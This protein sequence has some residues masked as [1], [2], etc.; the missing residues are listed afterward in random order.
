MINQ[1]LR[2]LSCVVLL[3]INSY[4]YADTSSEFYE[5]ALAKFN[6]EKFED[7]YIH[8]KNSLQQNPENLPAKIL[9]GKVLLI[10]GYLYEA[11]EILQESLASGADPSLIADTLGKVWLFTKQYDKIIDAKFSGLNNESRLEWQ[12]IKATANLNIKDFNGAREGYQKALKQAPNN[13]KVL[14]ALIAL[15]TQQ[16]NFDQAQQYLNTTFSTDINNA[17]TWRLQ[18]DL[19]LAKGNVNQAIEAYQKGFELNSSDPLIKRSLVSAFMQ[20]KDTEAARNLLNTVLEQTPDDPTGLLLKAWLLSM[21]QQNQEAIDQLEKLS[22][23]LASVTE[24]SQRND[25]SLIYISALAAYAQQNFQQ[26]KTYFI[27]YLNFV[28]DNIDAI[29]LLAETLLKLNQPKPALEAMQRHERKL[30]ENF[31][32]AL[33]LGELYLANDKAFKTVELLRKLKAD[34][35]NEPQV[36][37]LDIKTDIDRGKTQ[38]AL[39]RLNANPLINT[40]LGF[41]LTKTRL[42]I[43]LAEYSQANDI[44]DQLLSYGPNN[45]E[46]LNLKAAVLIKLQNWEDAEKY[47]DRALLES[48]ENFSGR[49]AKA[50]ILS[51]QKKFD[52]ALDLVNGLSQIQPDNLSVL[53][54]KGSIL[55][56]L[57]DREGAVTH[58]ERVL[59]K[60]ISNLTAMQMLANIYIANG[61]LDK[62]IR[63]LS[64]A[65]K[66]APD[67]ISYQLQ[68]I[69]VYLD[70]KQDERAK[71]ELQK[72]IHLASEDPTALLQISRLQFKANE[73]QA[74]QKSVAMAYQLMPDSFTL[75]QEY[76]RMFI[77]TN[78]LDEARKM[79]T[80]WLNKRPKDPQLLV[81][82]GD[83]YILRGLK[84]EASQEYF[85]ALQS[86]PEYRLALV[87]LYALADDDI[88]ADKFTTVLSKIVEQY[89]QRHFERSILADH[90]INQGNFSAAIPHYERLL[91][92]EGLPNKANVLNNLA[93]I[94]IE[95]DILKAENY[96]NEAM[97]ISQSQASIQDTYGWIQSLKGKWEQG[98]TILRRAHAMD[99]DDPSN[100]YHLAYTL[101]KLGR[102]D[103]A[104]RMLQSAL[105]TKE[106]FKERSKAQSL[107]N[108]L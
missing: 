53:L 74:A 24:E 61:E 101:T 27:Q 20:N 57:G 30:L 12:I 33:L 25:P 41:I 55:Y 87:K 77:A 37:L 45:V 14:N 8:L 103:E 95:S 66:T 72:V 63:Q 105:N 28:P 65:I 18:G 42:L 62:A 100:Q 44:A 50:T 88:E 56:N 10:S 36:E 94:Y 15:E 47:I 52:E 69:D 13:V 16:Q 19:F 3:C 26:A 1:F 89:P 35:P 104:K 91:K 32:Y 48:P 51:A 73:Y 7:A 80:T 68:R 9:M 43:S 23:N 59:E 34:Y 54:T 107:M 97:Q 98:L 85:S 76:I 31:N 70:Q 60:D 4:S 75:A 86:A 84:L 29:A 79:V 102:K 58:F 82:S 106:D 90:F 67:E 5:K 6:Q 99:S 83:I 92:V 108:S 22:S 96:I 71:R 11:E 64:S 2:I 21:R 17:I 81:L 46:F 49:F 93:N 78:K 40:H 39:Q 38:E